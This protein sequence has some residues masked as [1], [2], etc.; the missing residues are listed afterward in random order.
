MKAAKQHEAILPPYTHLREPP[1]RYNPCLVTSWSAGKDTNVYGFAFRIQCSG[2]G[3]CQTVIN[4]P[5]QGVNDFRLYYI[6][7][8]SFRSEQFRTP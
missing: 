8:L 5:T 2:L 1:I 7:L 3:Y 4:L 6:G